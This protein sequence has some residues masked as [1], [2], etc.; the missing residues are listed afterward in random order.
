MGGTWSRIARGA[1]VVWAAALSSCEDGA[2]QGSAETGTPTGSVD[3]ARGPGP[4][5]GGAPGPGPVTDGGLGPG[6][7]PGT[8]AAPPVR[9]V[10]LGT[11]DGVLQGSPPDWPIFTG[12]FSR[13]LREDEAA[14][15]EAPALQALGLK[16]ARGESESVWVALAAGDGSVSVTLDGALPGVTRVFSVGFVDGV[17]EVLRPLEPGGALPLRPNGPT[18]L[19]LDV[20]VAR[21]AAPGDH[22]ASLRLERPGRAPVN[23]PIALHVFDFDLPEVPRFESQMNLDMASLRGPDGAPPDGTGDAARETLVALRWASANSTW[24]S[25]FRWGIT[26]DAPENPRRC[27]ALY[28]EPD[29]PAPYSIGMI[30]PRVLGRFA[31]SSVFQFIDNHTPR[32]DTFCGVARGDH[33]GNAEYDAAWGRYLA[34]LSAYLSAEGHTPRT[35]A[36]LQNEPQDTTEERLAAH[37][38]RVARAAAPDLRIAVSEEPKPSVAEDPEGACGYDLWIAALQHY[39]PAYAQA[40]MRDHGETVWFYSLDHDPAPYF[41]PTAPGSPGMDARIVPWVAWRER[42]RGYAYYDAGRFLHAGVPGVRALL[43]RDGFEDYDYLY[44]AHGGQHPT[45]G[46]ERGVDTTV[47]GLASGLRD[48]SRDATALH[49]LRDA[50]GAY[51]GGER[52]SLPQVAPPAED[53]PRPRFVNFQ[54][55]DGPPRAEPLEVPQG[56]GR[57]YEKVGWMPFDAARGLG[58][59]GENVGDPTRA[60]ALYDEVPGFDE[61]QRS[62]VYDDWGRPARFDLVVPPGRYRVRVGL[63]RPARGYPNDPQNLRIEGM[64][65]VVDHVTT[66]DAPVLEYVG[67]HSVQDGKLSLD[68]GGRS[69]RTGDFAFTFLAYVDVEPLPPP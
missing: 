12:P 25:G 5:T 27:E 14:P 26:W 31:Q 68:F 33:R 52:D 19:V 15:T 49:T 30:A 40:R 36:Y 55:I 66:D 11:Y 20:R 60:L 22:G 8:D 64:P 37:L 51:L 65:A 61:R 1:T 67:E 24:P 3:A 48:F 57:L 38:C 21:D 17:A 13:K 35:Y 39:Q 42:A 16:A 6:P 44:L 32:P 2:G 10:A 7:G 47:A 29:E 50:V 4:S 23:V 58:F 18:G 62:V 54:A 46:V 28:L 43:L 45:V 63:G 53:P 56:S 69:A 9:P 34:A 59:T 41:N